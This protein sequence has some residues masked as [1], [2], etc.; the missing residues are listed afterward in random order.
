MTELKETEKGTE[1]GE[2]GENIALSFATDPRF[3]FRQNTRRI[4][5]ARSRA[6]TRDNDS[7][8]FLLCGANKVR[9][10][11]PRNLARL[12]RPTEPGN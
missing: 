1:R 11:V 10:T 6:V 2:L 9:Q 8:S 4:P 5:R 7:T 3:G 12:I